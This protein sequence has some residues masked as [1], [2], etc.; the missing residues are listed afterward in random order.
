M[1]LDPMIVEG[2][3]AIAADDGFELL[4]VEVAGSGA[5]TVVRLVIDGPTGV[6]LDQCA[7]ISRQ[8]SA[9][10]DVE[11]PLKHSYQLEVSSPG[12]D[13]K[14]YSK[15]DYSRFAGKRV[16]VRMAPAYRGRRN[17]VGELLGLE[18]DRVRV[19]EEDEAIVEL[20]LA[21]VFEARL[22]I[23]WEQVMKKGS[24]RR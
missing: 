18:N 10:L 20:P 23:D 6:N 17:V 5:H 22:E 2:I 7:L 21:E 16:R 14:L 9:L 24:R 8:A 13:R 12:M 19:A 1:K 15:S 3:R 11:D 4:A